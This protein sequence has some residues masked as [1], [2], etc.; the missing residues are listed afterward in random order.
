MFMKYYSTSG[1]FLR[2]M[3][4]SICLNALDIFANKKYKTNTKLWL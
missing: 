4:I 1:S 3:L 2:E